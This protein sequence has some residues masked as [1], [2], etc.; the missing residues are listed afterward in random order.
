MFASSTKLAAT[1]LALFASL[2]AVSAG[3]T[4]DGVYDG[5]SGYQMIDYQPP[6]TAPEGGEVWFAGMNYSASWSQA[7]PSGYTTENVS[8]T[9]DLVLG[10]KVDGE[11][12][13]HLRWTLATDIP[14]YAPNPDTVEFTLPS[15]LETKETYFL[16]L[17]GSTHNQS[18]EFT[19][20]ANPTA[21]S[22]G[23]L[24]SS[25]LS[26]A[27][28]ATTTP[29]SASSGSGNL[30][31]SLLGSKRMVKRSEAGKQRFVRD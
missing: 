31:D 11:T 17:L 30:F 1:A 4:P 22:S 12:S 15:E 9:A 28:A 19:V 21:A 29:A 6:F 10:Y 26:S 7:L 14:L 3:K 25:G 5:D 8:T 20:I 24:P 23:A 27:A 13:L 2:T 16:V 18:P